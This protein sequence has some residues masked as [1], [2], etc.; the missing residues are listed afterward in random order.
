MEN[1]VQSLDEACNGFSN[2]LND[3]VRL[4][5][6]SDVDV[7]SCL[8][9]GLDSSAIVAYASNI[10]KFKQKNSNISC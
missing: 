7:G 1:K 5:L 8:S 3:S 6:R 9:G 4:R 10:M 2:I